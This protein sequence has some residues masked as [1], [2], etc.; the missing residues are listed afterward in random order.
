MK[1]WI[2]YK[3]K[4]LKFCSRKIEINFKNFEDIMIAKGLYS[5]LYPELL[6]KMLFLAEEIKELK[7][8]IENFEE[9]AWCY[10]QKW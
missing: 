10:I 2:M 5:T 3:I 6:E 9:G 7:P 4:K 8:E 1:D